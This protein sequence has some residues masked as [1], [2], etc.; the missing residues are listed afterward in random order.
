VWL[1]Q[2]A[3]IDPEKS[4]KLEGYVEKLVEVRRKKNVTPDMARDYL[5]DPNYFGTVT[6]LSSR[7][8]PCGQRFLSTQHSC[9][10]GLQSNAVIVGDGTTSIQPC[11]VMQ[12]A[13]GM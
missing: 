5:H 6:A 2:C 7:I 10:R 8:Y 11:C 9:M 12:Q 3:I 13:C 1:A 4:D